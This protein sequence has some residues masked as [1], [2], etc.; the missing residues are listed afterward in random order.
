MLYSNIPDSSIVQL[1][2]ALC[3]RAS[4]RQMR[5][6]KVVIPARRTKMISKPKL[7]R[8]SKG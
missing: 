4:K 8:K 2:Y 6:V 3:T 5:E 7:E 1:T